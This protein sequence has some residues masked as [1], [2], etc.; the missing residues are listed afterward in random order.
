MNLDGSDK[1]YEISVASNPMENIFTCQIDQ[2]IYQLEDSK[3]IISGTKAERIVTIE[4][5]NYK[6]NKLPKTGSDWNL[7][8]LTAGIACV[9][10]AIWWKTPYKK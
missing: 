8:V 1:I 5:V 6:G 4:V 2:K 7:L 3:S 10:G 9:L